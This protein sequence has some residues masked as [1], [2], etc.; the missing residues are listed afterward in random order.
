MVEDML[1]H[2]RIGLTE[3]VV[4]GPGWAVL[5]YGRQSLGQGLSLGK[6]RDTTFTLTGMGTWVGMPAYLCH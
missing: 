3:A 1:C 2:G 6:A 4:M 5:F